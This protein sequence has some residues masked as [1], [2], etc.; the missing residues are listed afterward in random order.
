MVTLCILDGFGLSKKEKG[1]A[2]FEAGIPFL[3]K[4]MKEYPNVQIEA[5]GNAVGLPEGQMGTS[6]V[7]HMNLGAGRVVY[8]ELA[9][10][11]NIENPNL[12]YPGQVLKV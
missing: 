2:V 1:N 11:N 8:Q 9:R 10:I 4:L 5:S 3:D 12:I 7:G 6:E